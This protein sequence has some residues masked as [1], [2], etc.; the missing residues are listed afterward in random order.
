MPTVVTRGS[1]SP[2]GSS[3][4]KIPGCGFRIAPPN[5]SWA[6]ALGDQDTLILEAGNSNCA[7]RT[8]ATSEERGRSL[9]ILRA[10]SARQN[11]RGGG[12]DRGGRLGAASRPRRVI[13]RECEDDSSNQCESAQSEAD[14]R[15]P[16][17]SPR[18]HI[19]LRTD[20]QLFG[21][22]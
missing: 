20:I 18:K 1:A 2:L 22:W 16:R 17:A 14:L 7:F 9:P 4:A 8:A 21:R 11:R 15:P 6:E 12:G 5:S 3:F 19:V 10:G 13:C